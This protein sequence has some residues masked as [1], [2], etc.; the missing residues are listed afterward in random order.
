V[1]ESVAR[2]AALETLRDGLERDLAGRALVNGA[3]SPRAHHVAS[4]AFPG[5]RGDELAAA[6]DLEG[7]RVSSG[8]ACTAGTSE[9]STVITAMLGAERALQ[10]LRVSLGEETTAAEVAEFVRVLGAI[11]GRGGER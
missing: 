3:A 1:A 6:L 9:P 11:L 8:S 10:T 4:L 5:R 2:Y 7:V